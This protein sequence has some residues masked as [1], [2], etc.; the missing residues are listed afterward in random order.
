MVCELE[1]GDG[2]YLGFMLGATV[3]ILFS[4]PHVSREEEDGANVLSDFLI[5]VSRYE[6]G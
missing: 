2:D 4:I 5:S 1:R 6:E 3:V